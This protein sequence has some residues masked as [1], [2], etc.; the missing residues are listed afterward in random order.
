[1]NADP[2]PCF[3]RYYPDLGI[4]LKG[5]VSRDLKGMC[6]EIFY[7]QFFSWFEPIWAPDKQASV[8]ISSR[9]SIKSPCKLTVILMILKLSGPRTGIQEGVADTRINEV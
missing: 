2:Q 9:Y 5:T 8:S 6:H 3:I 1:M 4:F 7:L